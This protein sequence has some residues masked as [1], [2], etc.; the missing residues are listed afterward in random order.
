MF[1]V[2]QLMTQQAWVPLLILTELTECAKDFS[3]ILDDVVI[4]ELS[5]S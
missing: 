1:N 2:S 3:L 4:T 5:F